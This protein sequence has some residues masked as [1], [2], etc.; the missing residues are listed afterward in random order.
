MYCP[1]VGPLPGLVERSFVLTV[2]KPDQ[3]VPYTHTV[4]LFVAKHF[5]SGHIWFN[6]VTLDIYSLSAVYFVLF[7]APAFDDDVSHWCNFVYPTGSSPAVLDV[8]LQSK[9]VIL[10]GVCSG[11]NGPVTTYESSLRISLGSRDQVFVML[12]FPST[13]QWPDTGTSV[14]M[15]LTGVLTPCVSNR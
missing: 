15:T 7:R 11:I 2:L 8:T 12:G 13:D 1:V 3:P 9:N 10:A 5:S 4:P 14:A 6:N